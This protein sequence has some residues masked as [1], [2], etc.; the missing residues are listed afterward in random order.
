MLNGL[1]DKKSVDADKM[2]NAERLDSTSL[3]LSL[4]SVTVCVFPSF[5]DPC[6]CLQWLS[7]TA[8][9]TTSTSTAATTTTTTTATTTAA[10]TTPA[11]TATATTTTTTTATSTTTTATS[12]ATTTTT[13]RLLQDHHQQQRY[14]HHHSYPFWLKLPFRLNTLSAGRPA[15]CAIVFSHG[16]VAGSNSQ[17]CCRARSRRASCTFA[18]FASTV[19]KARNEI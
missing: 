4:L 13:T 2:V 19:T 18:T 16:V 11:N 15:H 14:H 8:T 5:N 1:R 7:T 3:D 12:T 6:N 9:S 17:L 10:A